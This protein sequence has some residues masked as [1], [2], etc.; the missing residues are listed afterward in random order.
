MWE[1]LRPHLSKEKVSQIEEAMKDPEIE[2]EDYINEE[3]EI[4]S[5]KPFEIMSLPHAYA[6]ENCWLFGHKVNVIGTG[7]W[8]EFQSM[9]ESEEQR[10]KELIPELSKMKVLGSIFFQMI[11]IAVLNYISKYIQ[12]FLNI[13]PAR[14]YF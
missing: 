8:M 1:F 9:I 11:V 13:T 12:K 2:Y 3:L 5:R 14:T 6:K 10:V 4:F 7:S